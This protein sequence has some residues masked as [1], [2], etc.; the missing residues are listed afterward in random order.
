MGVSPVIQAEPIGAVDSLLSEQVRVGE[1]CGHN[2][3]TSGSTGMPHPAALTHF[4]RKGY[5]L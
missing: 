5:R 3:D 2:C 4:Y 1:Q